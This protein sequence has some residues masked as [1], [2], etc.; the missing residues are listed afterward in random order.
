MKTSY[1]VGTGAAAVIAVAAVF[2]PGWEGMTT[3]AKRDA[4]GKGHPMEYCYGQTDEFGAVKAG[5]RFTK[6]QCDELLAKSLPKYLSEIDRCMTR[7]MPVKVTASFL[8]AA[9]NTGSG[10]V[11]FKSPMMRLA[12]QGRFKEACNAFNGW[13]VRSLNVVRKGLIARRAGELHGDTRKSERALCLEGLK[14]TDW[15]IPSSVTAVVGRQ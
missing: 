9:Y 13:Y 3:V 5:T 15:Y 11:C 1:K 14:E 7:P 8:S 2:L 6:Q 12:N 4:I 10:A